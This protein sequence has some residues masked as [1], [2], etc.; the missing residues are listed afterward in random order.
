IQRLP[1]HG[2]AHLPEVGRTAGAVG[3]GGLSRLNAGINHFDTRSIRELV[4]LRSLPIRGQD[5]LMVRKLAHHVRN[6]LTGKSPKA[7]A[8]RP[9]TSVDADPHL[10]L[11]WADPAMGGPAPTTN[12]RLVLLP[13][14]PGVDT[15]HREGRA[16]DVHA[17]EAVEWQPAG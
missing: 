15:D 6:Q 11:S 4:L 16:Q 13:T 7:A 3:C 12:S 5:K 10:R 14:R 9:A 17:R 2:P 8:D 1:A